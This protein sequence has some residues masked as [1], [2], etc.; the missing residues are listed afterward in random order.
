[1]FTERLNKIMKIIGAKPTDIA[2]II[3]CSASFSAEQIKDEIMRW[4]YDGEEPIKV[5]KEV[6]AVLHTHE[7]FGQ[8]FSSILDLAKFSNVR[9]GKLIN[10]DPSYISRFCNGLRTP[11]SNCK[12][13]KEMCHVLYS[14][15][16]DQKC[17][18][19][20]AGFTSFT[21]SNGIWLK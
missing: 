10:I 3:G 2:G 1:M 12:L 13:T 9:F 19:D 14:R 11:V 21:I 4:L 18:S 7:K 8:R 20:L 15:L 16:K 6:P 17:L 5:S